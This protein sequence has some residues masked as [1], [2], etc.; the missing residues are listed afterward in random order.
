MYKQITECRICGNRNLVSLL[1]LGEQSL[2][3]H[4]PKAKSE[5]VS[6]GPLELVKCYSDAQADICGLVQLNHSFVLQE[7][8]SDNYGYR[9][10]L[11]GSMVKHLRQVVDTILGEI[12]L[13]HG[14]LIVDIGSN[15]STLLGGYPANNGY[16]LVGVDP[17]TKFRKYYPERIELIS[18]FFS[19]DLVASHFGNQ[20][21][22]IITSI[23]MFY[24]LEAPLDFVQHVSDVLHDQG[25]WVFEQSYLP[26]MLDANSYD[27]V[28]HEHL[29]YYCLSQ[30]IWMLE[31]VGLKVIDVELND[32]I[33]RSF[34]S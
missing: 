20:K 9:S 26:S 14:D 24:D 15:D 3:G 28:C 33:V 19:S 11:N 5:K 13:E 25:V 30:I 1:H 34:S 7:M 23:A 27:T 2:T 17:I 21:A 32:V 29:E 10:G 4:F 16:R 6:S 18:E 12:D 22:K 31:K 8:Y